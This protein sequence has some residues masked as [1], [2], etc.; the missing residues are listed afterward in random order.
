MATNPIKTLFGDT[1]DDLLRQ[2][3]ME[4]QER[5]NQARLLDKQSG[6]NYYSGLIADAAQQQANVFSNLL[7]KGVRAVGGLLGQE[8]AAGRLAA[9]MED[10]RLGKARQRKADLD[11]LSKRYETLGTDAD[12]F[13]DKDAKVIVDDL[14]S[15]GYLDEAKK[16]A[17]IWQGRRLADAKKAAAGGSG[18]FGLKSTTVLESF[19]D[20]NSKR[21]MRVLVDK[22]KD[23]SSKT[24]ILDDAG[25]EIDPDTVS[26][27]TISVDK[28]GMT[29]EGRVGEA[30]KKV[31]YKADYE[32]TIREL[33]AWN[34]EKFEEIGKAPTYAYNMNQ[35]DT[36]L[37]LLEKIPTTGGLAAYAKE[38]TDFFGVT[39][40]NIEEF[41]AKTR[42]YVTTQ[43]QMMGR[44]PTDFDLKFLLKVNPG[45]LK[46]RSGNLRILTLLKA[47]NERKYEL[48]RD[49]GSGD[50]SRDR[51]Y[52]KIL[53]P[54]EDRLK[55]WRKKRE[56]LFGEPNVPNPDSVKTNKKRKK[57]VPDGRG[58]F[59]TVDR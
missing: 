11:M 4:D 24:Y 32:L 26:G 54:A 58:G 18:K 34:K 25:R 23:G 2:M 42:E 52:N 22:F 16:M 53:I 20:K 8:D 21:R 57:V 43:L 30:G 56:E 28:K 50:Y 49:L 19:I 48:A 29:S 13:T 27:L 55:K 36:L 35:A 12:G 51:W 5:V 47:H 15:L 59:K 9:G 33:E 37:G 41:D 17:E 31:K 46:S 39:P 14:I 3:R 40:A 45:M 6:G 44:N 10:P 7:P 38:L 1:E